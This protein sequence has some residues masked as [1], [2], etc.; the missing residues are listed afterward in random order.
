MIS[1]VYVVQS[2]RKIGYFTASSLCFHLP[3]QVQTIARFGGNRPIPELATFLLFQA[4]M[5]R[6]S[7]EP[8]MPLIRPGQATRPFPRFLRVPSRAMKT[9]VQS[10][11][12]CRIGRIIS[13]PCCPCRSCTGSWPG[14]RD[15]GWFELQSR[16]SRKPNGDSGSL[17][18]CEAR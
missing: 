18:R 13:S 17:L 10:S 11:W 4:A 3:A 7:P 15:K 1:V 12:L 9:Q 8:K 2:Y 6:S 5:W 16:A 14:Q